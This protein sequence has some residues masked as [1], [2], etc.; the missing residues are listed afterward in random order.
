MTDHNAV[1][2][3]VVSKLKE[4]NA[5]RGCP[6]TREEQSA[7]KEL[8]VVNESLQNVASMQKRFMKWGG[9]VLTAVVIVAARDIYGFILTVWHTVVK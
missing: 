5:F 8:V 9:L 3:A 2:D 1:A 7:V 4:D 6:L